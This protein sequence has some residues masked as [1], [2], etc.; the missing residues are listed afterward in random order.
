[1]IKLLSG[2]YI[3]SPNFFLGHNV[4]SHITVPNFWCFALLTNH[5][6]HPNCN[7]LKLELLNHMPFTLSTN[8]SVL[9][10]TEIMELNGPANLHMG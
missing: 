2:S 7:M 8:Q 6:L 1:M 9:T 3:F 5:N 4:A 10:K